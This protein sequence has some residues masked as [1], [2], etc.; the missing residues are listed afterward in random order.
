MEMNT[1]RAINTPPIVRFMDPP[2]P[3]CESLAAASTCGLRNLS[4]VFSAFGRSS[5]PIS[6]SVTRRACVVSRATLAPWPRLG[7]Q[8]CAASPIKSTLSLYTIE[9]TVV[10][11]PPG[12]ALCLAS[13][14]LVFDG[15]LP[16][17]ASGNF[18]ANNRSTCCGA[19]ILS[20]VHSPFSGKITTALCVPSGFGG[21]NT[22]VCP[23]LHV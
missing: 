4:N 19:S 12:E 17:K 3:P 21:A 14:E 10:V 5:S 2:K 6:S 8:L 18:V 16:E 7:Q 13:M 15:R 1:I 22:L 11:V 9:L 20:H 23:R